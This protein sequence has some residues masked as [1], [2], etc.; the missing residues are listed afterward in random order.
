MQVKFLTQEQ[1]GSAVYAEVLEV[2]LLLRG[3]Y[4]LETLTAQIKKQQAQG[5]QLVYVQSDTGILAVAGFVVTEKL[6][7][8]KFKNFLLT[9]CWEN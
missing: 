2:L 7:W 6:A 5:Y 4:R 8:G 1:D 3:Q 9:S